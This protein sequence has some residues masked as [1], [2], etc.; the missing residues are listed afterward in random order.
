MCIIKQV[1]DD[2][3]LPGLFIYLFYFFLRGR[4][5]SLKQTMNNNFTNISHLKTLDYTLICVAPPK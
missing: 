2:L 3:W 5:Y 4:G 1:F